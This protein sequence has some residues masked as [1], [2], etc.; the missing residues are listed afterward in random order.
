[1]RKIT[2]INLSRDQKA[3]TVRW[4][5]G[6]VTALALVA[7]PAIPKAQEKSLLWRVHSGQ[8]SV[9]ILGSIHF[10]KKENYP[11]KKNIEN[12]LD[13]AKKL[14]LE[15]D[16]QAMDS[17]K[18]QQLTIQK[19][20][21]PDGSTLEQNV[22]PETY[23]LAEQKARELGID[24]R[25]LNPFKPW[26]VALTLS[27]LKLQKLGLDPNYGVD[28]YLAERAKKSGK[29]IS[30][31]ETFEFQIGLFD[32][33]SPREQQLMLRETLEEMDLLEKSADRIVQA[34]AKGDTVSLEES[35]LAGMREYPELFQK[36]IVE[37]NRRWLPQIERMLKQGESPLIAVG[38]AHLV[39]K[40]GIIE[41]LKQQGYT[42]EQL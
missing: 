9:T 32:R 8:N 13:S 39:G 35:L 20:I 11:L 31:L 41:L 7:I 14:V 37:R 4:L 38:A 23:A 12:A 16:L 30:G 1:M 26:F 6:L 28:R 2:P 36:L 3:E 40:D 24:V 42:V 10:L 5:C 29:P 19:A 34:W 17:E 27:A 15:I 25:P 33:L 18:A 22:S 21:N